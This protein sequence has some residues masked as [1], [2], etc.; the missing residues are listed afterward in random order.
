MNYGYDPIDI[1]V[2]EAIRDGFHTHPGNDAI[3]ELQL[4]FSFLMSKCASNKRRGLSTV[5][6]Y[7]EM[8]K[9]VK[10]V[11]QLYETLGLPTYIFDHALEVY[12]FVHT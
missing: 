1:S 7:K 3:L 12:G 5:Q 11:K 10:Q 2:Y 6:V 9:V 8:Y 4:E